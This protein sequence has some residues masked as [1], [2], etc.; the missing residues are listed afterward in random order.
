[1]GGKV[2]QAPACLERERR[3]SWSRQGGGGAGSADVLQRGVAVL[4]LGRSG[5]LLLHLVHVRHVRLRKQKRQ[6]SAN[7]GRSGRAAAAGDGAGVG[8]LNGEGAGAHHALGGLCGVR[9]VELIAA[10]AAEVERR[11]QLRDLHLLSPLPA[12]GSAAAP[13]G[14]RSRSRAGGR[15]PV[16]AH[17]RARLGHVLPMWAGDALRAAAAGAC[18]RA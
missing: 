4:L 9:H 2:N 13:A 7:P 10:A 14:W 18:R 3:G 6:S 8:D 15:V 1:M 16:A 12:K 5:G 17:A 11:R